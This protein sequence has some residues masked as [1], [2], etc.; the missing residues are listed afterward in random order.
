MTV[1]FRFFSS[2]DIVDDTSVIF[3]WKHSIHQFDDRHVR[4]KSAIQAANSQPSTPPPMISSR[5]GIAVEVQQLLTRQHLPPVDRKLRQDRAR[6]TRWQS[7]IASALIER[8][9]PSFNMTRSRCRSW[10][11]PV[12]FPVLNIPGLEEC[13]DA[14]HEARHHLVFSGHHLR[15]IIGHRSV[16]M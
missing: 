16:H 2:R 4:P 13:S 15:E 10:S 11:T 12:A 8:S 5:L 9:A 14:F 6:T 1:T 7:S 3:Q